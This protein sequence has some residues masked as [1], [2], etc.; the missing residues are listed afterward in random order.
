MSEETKQLQGT[1]ARKYLGK[2]GIHGISI[3][4]EHQTVDV[5]IDEPETVAPT[6]DKLRKDAGALQV[7]TIR[8]PRARLV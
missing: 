8:S 2:R 1:L 7:R 6:M 5:Y 4:E 3:D